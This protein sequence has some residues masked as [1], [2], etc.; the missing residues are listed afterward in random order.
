MTEAR[1]LSPSALSRFLGCAHAETLARELRGSS[2]TFRTSD[3]ELLIRAKGD[4]HERQY[5]EDLKTRAAVTTIE[6]V[7][8]YTEMA[9]R[10]REAMER[11]DEAIFQATFVQG[12]WRGHADFLERV[13][14]ETALGAYGYEAV[15]T[16][17]ARN[18]A[19]PAH[20]LQLCFYSA[21]IA[22]IQGVAPVSMHLQ[23]GSGRRESLRPRDF[24]AYFARAQRS[25]ERFTDARA[26]TVAMRCSACPQCDFSMRCEAEWR[27]RDDLSFVAGIRHSQTVSLEL[28][29]VRTLTALADPAVLGRVPSLSPETL[30]GLHEQAELQAATL[31]TGQIATRLRTPEPGRGFSLVPLPA[32]LDMAIDLEGD[33]FWRADRDLTFMFGLLERSG[34]GW[35]YRAEWAHD[36]VEESALA[37]HVIDAI[38]ARL[39]ADPAMHVYHYG[40]VEVSVLKRICMLNATHEERL[41]ELLRGHVFVDVV[42][43]VRQ[44]VRIGLES[45]GLKSV[46]KLPG[47]V[48]TADVGRGADAVLEYERWL[49]DGDDAH[50]AAIERYNDEDC[51]STVAVV[52]WLRR[53]APSGVAWLQPRADGDEQE[54]DDELDERDL[55][56]LELVEGAAPGSERWLAGELLAYHRRAAKPQWWA[57]FARKE[58][59]ADGLREDSEALAGLVPQPQLA[60]EVVAQSLAH[61]LRFPAQEHKVSPGGYLD[62]HTGA[63]ANVHRLDEDAGLVWVRRGKGSTAPL[64]VAIVPSA[65]IPMTGHVDALE[66]LALSVRNSTGAYPA[67]ER[68]L[69]NDL[70]VIAGRPA[71]AIVQT[72]DLAE[73][74]A[75]ALGL[76]SS[77]LVIQGPPGTGKTYT[78]ARLITELVRAGKRV[79]ITAF[80]HK[81]IDNLCREIE[82][83]AAKEGLTFTGTR[84]GDAGNHDGDQI[85]RGS[86][87]VYPASAVVAATSWLF[88]KAAE[89]FDY[90]V[91]D[92]AGQFALAD[93]LAC[94]TGADNLILLGDPSQLSQVVQGTHPPGT[95]ASALGH[96]LGDHQTIPSDR[97]VFLDQSYRMHPD[98]CSFISQEFYDGRLGSHPSCSERSTSAGTG[99]R[100]L[101]VDHQGNASRSR[102]EAS[103]I[104]EEVDRL[105]RGTITD[106]NGT[107]PILPDDVMVVTPYNAQARTLRHALDGVRVGTVDKFQGQEAP[108]VFFSM[109][110][111][112]GED[113]P[114]NAGFLFSRN[115]LN[116][117]ISR[118]QSLAYLVC[119]PRLLDTRALHVEDMR[120]IN[121]LCRLA[122]V[123]AA[124]SPR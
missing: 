80:S 63:A 59:T 29:G 11:G 87:G 43:A 35:T 15:D 31:A 108:I 90:L 30:A 36:E 88:A 21:C 6:R 53:Q 32:V 40:A 78:G 121:T 109:A 67:L 119:S 45:Y 89:R 65:P 112:S 64:P 111:S 91:I 17:L 52:D 106:A 7:G 83:A 5:L 79:A 101:A 60:P 74:R 95:E 25:L 26:E 10:T 54:D 42:Q 76:E 114:R 92:E 16:K 50:L 9:A 103:A 68:V 24:G 41:D 73:L 23:L 77:T 22:D 75:R 33:P 8:S 115:R 105:L 117:A 100:M 44:A 46:E 58:L 69:R 48:R 55:L 82:K 38:H 62:A 94:G 3:Y 97:G 13:E 12:R 18:E 51:R 86:G 56:R 66:R 14:R 2:E 99:L 85:T 72:T 20:V 102:E 57:F 107:R 71:G 28:D 93:A 61:P 70:P 81:A 123:S 120:L 98:I 110:S 104:R 84:H 118:A 1:F 39:R 27:A 49:A 34:E 4:L 124:V 122:D 116:V 37:G 19:R 47:F 96:M 113:A